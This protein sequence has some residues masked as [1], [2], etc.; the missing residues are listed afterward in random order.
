VNKQSTKPVQ[1]IA[2]WIFANRFSRGIDDLASESNDSNSQLKYLRLSKYA[3]LEHVYFLDQ[4]QLLQHCLEKWGQSM[5]D[6]MRTT[7]DDRLR[8]LGI[9][10]LEDMCEYIPYFLSSRDPQTAHSG[11]RSHVDSWNGK[12]KLAAN[13]L[14]D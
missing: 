5:D 13:L 7:E 14:F 10:F 9:L 3:E 1:E 6:L 4:R 12:R 11:D 8:A 2:A